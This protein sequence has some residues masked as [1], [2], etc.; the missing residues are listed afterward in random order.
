MAV[1]SP[2]KKIIVFNEEPMSSGFAATRVREEHANLTVPVAP[3]FN[4]R[5]AFHLNEAEFSL[6]R[7][8]HQVLTRHVGFGP[9]H[10]VT[11]TDKNGRRL[12]AIRGFDLVGGERGHGVILR[13]KPA[14]HP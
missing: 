13:P 11:R 5:A 14:N 9:I 4:R 8:Y 2:S 12:G 10:A 7:A 6:G 3:P 1:L